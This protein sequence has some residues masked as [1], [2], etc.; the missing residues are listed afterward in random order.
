MS[1]WLDYMRNLPA[2]RQNRHADAL[3][4]IAA[5]RERMQRIWF[6]CRR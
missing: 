2:L 3:T 1:R 4:L 5:A 6:R